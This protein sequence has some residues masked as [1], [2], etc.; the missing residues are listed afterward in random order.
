MTVHNSRKNGEKTGK[1]MPP[2]QHQ[3][4]PGNRGRPKGSRNKLGEA[5]IEDLHAAWEKHGMAAIEATIKNQLAQFLRVIAMLM[6]K[7][8]N[9]NINPY[10]HMTDEQ[11]KAREAA[12]MESAMK[13]AALSTSFSRTQGGRHQRAAA[14]RLARCRVRRAL[15]R[16]W[17]EYGIGPGSRSAT[18]LSDS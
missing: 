6:P 2:V 13:C 10:D 5:F 15:Y 14:H 9:L 12:G 7:E 11:F 18:R 1:Q 16:P 17:L 3:F 4:K 8:L